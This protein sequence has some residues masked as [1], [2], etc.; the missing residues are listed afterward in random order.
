[1]YKNCF[2]GQEAVAWLVQSGHASS[3]A[4]AIRL[5][6][7]MMTHGLFHH[8]VY[9]HVFEDSY[10]FYRFTNEDVLDDTLP[11]A[12]TTGPHG[13]ISS[14]SGAGSLPAFASELGPGPAGTGA[15]A[16]AG[17]S[18]GPHQAEAGPGTN[19]GGGGGSKHATLNVTLARSA[20]CSLSAPSSPRGGHT[21]HTT[22][23]QA[24]PHMVPGATTTATLGTGSTPP[25]TAS[26]AAA[27]AAAAGHPGG[28]G[29]G[30]GAGGGPQSTS[31]GF[32]LLPETK[33]ERTRQ[34]VAGHLQ[35]LQGRVTRMQHTAEAQKA[36][37]EA[38]A[39]DVSA[40]RTEVAELRSA[41][42]AA[43]ASAAS[44]SAASAAVAQQ[45]AALRL[46]CLGMCGYALHQALM[47]WVRSGPAS[48][49]GGAGGPGSG[50]LWG[51]AMAVAL[52]LLALGVLVQPK[53][54]AVGG[55]DGVSPATAAVAPKG[56][57]TVGSTPAAAKGS[58][59]AT[60]ASA[61]GRAAAATTAAVAAAAS[62]SRSG[63]AVPDLGRV[64]K[65]SDGDSSG[66]LIADALIDSLAEEV[67]AA[68]VATPPPPPPPPPSSGRGGGGGGGGNSGRRR[69][70]A[71]G[72]V[73]AAQAAAPARTHATASAVPVTVQGVDFAARRARAA[74]FAHDDSTTQRTAAPAA[75]AASAAASSS[76]AHASAAAAAGGADAGADDD[77]CDAAPASAAADSVSASGGTVDASATVTGPAHS[78]MKK[79]CKNV[80]LKLTAPV[81]KALPGRRRSGNLG[82]DGPELLRTHSLPADE[83]APGYEAA[84][85]AR[86][87]GSPRATVGGGA[88]ASSKSP[89]RFA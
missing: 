72:G 50:P 44:A 53:P 79:R 37:A 38:L 45:A 77:A 34:V 84:M 69:V 71:T 8:V 52:T 87:P 6:N 47:Q 25:S 28:G 42:A 23:E 24:P 36:A 35:Q 13:G 61:S 32:R 65:T 41:L 57:A 7:L 48:G 73:E 11:A 54:A 88:A 17:P 33:L 56:G 55:A 16:P 27:A 66:S 12:P 64:S 1:M 31:S 62:R 29:G 2:V 4:D 10:L 5:G 49:F 21:G 76:V 81:R 82:P 74:L 59:A 83:K 39:G 85:A 70:S 14:P 22:L 86:E 9:E 51:V 60:A 68:N 67:A 18:G 89:S 40:L 63:E 30:G 19:G 15:C 78:S 26:G 43:A 80:A 3:P 20:S 58:S 46:L 75:A